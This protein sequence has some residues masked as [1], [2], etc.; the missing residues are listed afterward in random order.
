MYIEF[1]V[2]RYSSE[3]D[4]VWPKY[5]YWNGYYHAQAERDHHTDG[6]VQYPFQKEEAQKPPDR[7]HSLDLF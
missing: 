1:F 5:P 3:V 6:H 7:S 2:I 4:V